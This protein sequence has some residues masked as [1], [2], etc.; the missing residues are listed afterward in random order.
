MLADVCCICPRRL[1]K[2]N[3][4]QKEIQIF[5]GFDDKH[6]VFSLQSSSTLVDYPLAIY[7]DCNRTEWFKIYVFF[8]IKST[9]IGSI[10][11][12]SVKCMDYS[13]FSSLILFFKQQ[14]KQN[15]K[16]SLNSVS[17][18]LLLSAV[19]WAIYMLSAVYMFIEMID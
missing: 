13:F 3:L 1:R 11:I 19:P 2:V 17:L 9:S 4:Q 12:L 10:N 8:R 15:M 5:E 7:F 14:P 16:I 18:S 6:T